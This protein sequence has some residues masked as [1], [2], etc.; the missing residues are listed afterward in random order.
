MTKV[1]NLLD[2]RASSQAIRDRQRFPADYSGRHTAPGPPAQT[3]CFKA[4][5]SAKK[6]CRTLSA[7]LNNVNSTE[8][9]LITV[10]NLKEWE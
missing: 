7:E 10:G 5:K 1:F 2:V 6:G 8:T 3:R 4:G 9:A